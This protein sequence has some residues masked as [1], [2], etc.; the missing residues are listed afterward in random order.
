MGGT[1]NNTTTT[2]AATTTSQ[3]P[4]EIRA[5]GSQITNAAMNTYFDPA[6]KY[7]AFTPSNTNYAQD[8]AVGAATTGQLNDKNNLTGSTAQSFNDAA[9]NYQPYYGAAGQVAGSSYTNGPNYNS[10]AIQQFQNPYQQQ[11]IDAGVGQIGRDLTSQMQSNADAA[12][13]AGAF[14][15]ARHGVID[16]MS[17]Q[18]SALA[19]QN[20]IANQESAGFQ[21]AQTQFNTN[22]NQTQAANA[23]NQSLATTLAGIGSGQ[24]N[25]AIAAGN[26]NLNL[27]NVNTAQD[28]AQKTNAFTDG[29]QMQQQY[30]MDIYSQL[31][32]MNAMQPINR[33]TTSTGSSSGTSDTS[34]GWLGPALSAGG[35]VV[36][37]AVPF[38]MGSDERAKEDIEDVDPEEVLGAFSK[39]PA[40]SYRYKDEV[41]D[42][43]PELTR[44]GRRTGFM[45]QDAERAF[46]R[47]MGPEIDGIKTVDVSQMLGELMVAVHGLEKRTRRLSPGVRA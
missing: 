24:S 20:Y 25:Q 34:G 27:G 47:S 45:A 43:H 19:L 36:S 4:E 18:T 29:Y 7:Q 3:I 40:K 1:T 28:Q 41:L 15:G 5:R 26:A 37:A 32:A 33:T 31:A 35:S 46:G 12:A 23:Q 10:A 9:N 14:G 17:Q 39:I 38:L 44:P 11:V 6:Q 30:P 22:Q 2:N 13:Q 21:N 16:G 42:S 8:Q